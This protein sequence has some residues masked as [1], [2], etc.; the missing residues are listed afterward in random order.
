FGGNGGVHAPDLARQLGIPR[1]VVPPM[2]G[3]F[4]AIGM[5]ASD[6]EHTALATVTKRLDR[7]TPSELKVL[8]SGL[9]SQVSV[10]LSADGYPAERRKFLFEADLRHEGQAS[11]LTV[12]F[13]GE[14]IER[15]RALFVAE[16]EKTYGYRDET[17]I[18]LMKLR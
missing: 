6:I 12:R 11:E 7:L 16:Y 1:V 5:L 15:I 14:D 2:S 13:E 17:P 8:K 9:E 10:L 3:I 18:E 4:C